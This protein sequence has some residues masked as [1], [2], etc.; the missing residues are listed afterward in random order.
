M[1]PVERSVLCFV[2]MLGSCSGIGCSGNAKQASINGKVT[3]DGVAVPKGSIRFIP[4][5]GKSTTAGGIIKDGRY[6]ATVPVGSVSVEIYSPK[7]VGKR[8]RYETPDSPID[9]ILGERMPAKFNKQSKLVREIDG[10]SSEVDFELK[11]K[12]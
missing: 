2:L 1:K 10:R 9:D 8:K 11:T 12:D 4:K 3:L 5:D 6:E 7:V